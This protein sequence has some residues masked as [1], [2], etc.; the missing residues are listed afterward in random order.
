MNRT[1]CQNKNMFI[2]PIEVQRIIYSYDSTY[3]IAFNQV[4]DELKQKQKQQ[5][6]RATFIYHFNMAMFMGGGI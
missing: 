2:L 3:K 1:I 5:Q 6:A 4:V